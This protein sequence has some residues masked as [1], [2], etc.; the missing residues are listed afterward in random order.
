MPHS[1]REV[2]TILFIGRPGSGKET[3]ARLLA[4]KTGYHLFSTG[5]RFRELREHRDSLGERIKQVYDTGKLMPTWFASYLF[6]DA[7]LH[8]SHGTGLIFEGTGRWREEAELFD[9]VANWLG[10][11]YK[12][13]LLNVSEEEAMRRQL[14]RA[15]GTD[16]PDSNSEEKVRVRFKE[17]AAHTQQAIDFFQEKGVLITIDGEKSMEDIA[18]DIA[19]AL[20]IE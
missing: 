5:E 17:F 10:R 15:E 3:Q 8:T 16:R 19:A 20:D 11:Q 14:S 7:L 18:A 12:V 9:E 4:E 1:N 6:E 2:R 13:I